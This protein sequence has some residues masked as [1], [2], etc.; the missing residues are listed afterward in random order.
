MGPPLGPLFANGFM[1]ELEKDIIQSLFD[2][3]FIKFYI[4]YVDNTLLVVKDED[5][6]PIL[7]ELN[8]YNKN[9]D[10]HFL[11]IKIH[12]NNTDIYYKDIHTGYYINYRN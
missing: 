3:K 8:S 11:D 10:V 2:K 7:K 12:Q 6:Y 1:T 4:Q 5:I 9:G